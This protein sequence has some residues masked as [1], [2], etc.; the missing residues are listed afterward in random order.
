MILKYAFGNSTVQ[1]FFDLHFTRY[2]NNSQ[3]HSHQPANIVIDNTNAT[4][5]TS[6]I[7][8]QNSPK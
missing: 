1:R 6:A 7:K 4:L 5:L 2:K 8:Y 3:I